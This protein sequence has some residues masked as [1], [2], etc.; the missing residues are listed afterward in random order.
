MSHLPL[1]SAFVALVLTLSLLASAPAVAAP[2]EE[3][4]GPFPSWRDLKRD[5]GAAGDGK[6]DD[7]PALQR[8]FDDLLKHEK[9]CVLYVPA[10]KYRLTKTVTTTRK[11]H[12]DCMGVTVVGE[13]PA[14]P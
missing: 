4:A 7:T 11:E 5:Y 3:F 2:D 10:G 9:A 6:A 14:T 13:D 8:A 1:R 12:H